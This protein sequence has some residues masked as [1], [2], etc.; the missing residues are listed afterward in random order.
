MWWL[1]TTH[2]NLM[3]APLMHMWF[4][5][6]NK[7]PKSLLQ[8]VIPVVAVAKV[9]ELFD[10]VFLPL[11]C[12]NIQVIV[13]DSDPVLSPHSVIENELR[14]N[15][16][17]EASVQP[18]SSFHPEPIKG[19]ICLPLMQYSITLS[20]RAIWVMNK[21]SVFSQAFHP[22]MPSFYARD[23]SFD[24]DIISFFSPVLI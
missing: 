9:Q 11:F 18:S 5:F 12:Y 22:G 2:P 4:L 14:L 10:C 24:V 21:S 6:F 13:L 17:Q 19:G 1:I 8:L 3:W 23:E 20:P 7:S 15:S 16:G